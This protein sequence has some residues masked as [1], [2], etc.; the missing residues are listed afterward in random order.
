MSTKTKETYKVKGMHCASCANV[1]SRSLSK[2]PGVEQAQGFYGTE[3]AVVQFDPKKTDLNKLNQAVK[4][5]GYELLSDQ[6]S[7]HDHHG[8]GHGNEAAHLQLEK[9]KTETKYSLPIAFLIFIGMMWELL[10]EK[11]TFISAF[12]IPEEPWMFLQF[13]FASLVLFGLGGSFLRALWSFVRLGK[14]N[15]DTLVGL[16]TSVAYLYS[17]LAMF[18]PDFFEKVGLLQHLYFDV[19]IIVIVFVKF[20]KY[21]EARSKLRTG[22]AL[23]ALIKLQAKT[24]LVKRGSEYVE[25]AIEQVLVDDIIK[26]K[27]GSS[28]PVDGLVIEGNSNIDESMITGESLPLSKVK[29]DKIVAGT[30]N[31]DGVLLVQAKQVGGETVLAKIVDLVKSAQNSKA[32]IERLADQVSAIF[33]PI[34]ILIAV[35]TLIVWIFLPSVLSFNEALALGLSCMI[36]VLVIA[37][38]CALG[39]ATPT[40]MIVGVGKAAKRGIL[41]KNAESLEALHKVTTIVFDKTGTLTTGKPK[42]ERI[43]ITSKLSEKEILKIAAGLENQSEHPLAQAVMKESL[44]QKIASPEVTDFRNLSGQGVTGKINKQTYWLLSE[45]A[46]LKKHKL[47]KEIKF[48]ARAGESLLYLLDEKGILGIITVADQLK[49]T[50]AEAVNK[51]KRLGIKL[52]M[53]SGDRQKTAEYFAKNLGID[54]AIGEVKPDQ[55]LAKIKELQKSGQTVAMVG[56]GINDAPALAAADVGIAM[57]TGTEVAMSTAQATILRGDLLK[58][59]TA[60]A[61]SKSVMRTVRQNLFWAFAYNVL[62]IPL[63]AGLF[64]PVFGWLLNP[65]FAGMAMAFSS[66]SVVLNSLRL[67]LL[68]S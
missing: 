9:E 40:A 12:P 52:V 38:P 24:A 16:G 39:L 21:L 49:D 54:E 67:K 10:A 57:S 14:A 58:V 66:V 22:E 44:L 43:I 37:C 13:L 19:T 2:V 45:V 34:V 4:P 27:P 41:I 42:L 6:V 3:E 46:A 18:M 25:I 55:K 15:M 51:L 62:G 53:L 64:Y 8:N 50:T 30:L 7:S 20:G 28:I 5:Y 31:V 29:G 35:L 32:P 56:D 1:I 33:V 36:A 17:V 47:E 26:I 68:D 59:E 60:I 48:E 61:I 63:A 23:S 65:A 11:F